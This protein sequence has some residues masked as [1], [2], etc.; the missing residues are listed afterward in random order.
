MQTPKEKK[1]KKEKKNRSR[2]FE[3]EDGIRDWSVTGV[4]TCALPIWCLM[5]LGVL[6]LS[7]RRQWQG[8]VWL[9]V[10]AALIFLIGSTPL[11]DAIVARAERPWGG[12]LEDRGRRDGTQM[13]EDGGR[14]TEDR[15]RRTE[16]GISTIGNDPQPSTL[17][18]SV[19]AL[20]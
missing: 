17:P 6:W 8:A 10:P 12:G 4:Q 16:E 11:V 7:W 20:P 14:S 2:L 18:S 3:A 9:G 13:T 19:A 5:V 15:G 1:E